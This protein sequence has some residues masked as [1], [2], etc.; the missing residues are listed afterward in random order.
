M[1]NFLYPCDSEHV[2]ANNGILEIRKGRVEDSGVYHCDASNDV[3]NIVSATWI[4]V[5]GE[6]NW[7][8]KLS[9]LFYKS[10]NLP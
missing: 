8:L 1:N 3:G 10:Q 4:Q 6:K 5:V 7:L 9:G 2:K